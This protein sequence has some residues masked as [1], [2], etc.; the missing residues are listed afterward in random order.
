[1]SNSS[2]HWDP[3][4]YSTHSDIQFAITM[5]VLASYSFNGNEVVLD[6]GCGDGRVSHQLSLRVPEG[7][8]VGID[9]SASMIHFA[10]ANHASQANLSFALKDAC[11]LD[12][13][14]EFDV[15]V[16]TFCL[17]WVPD[18]AAAFGGIRRSLRPGGAAILVM[19]FRNQEIAKLRKEMTRETRWNRHFVDYSDPSDCADDRQYEAYARQAGFKIHSYRIGETSGTFTSGTSFANFLGALTPHLERLPGEED[20]RA[21]MEELVTRYLALMPPTQN[22]TGHTTYVYVCASMIATSG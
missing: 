4:K 8:V 18:K 10:Q 16:S 2:T 11:E 17:Q 7:R 9:S 5:A 20:K 22:N 13:M 21:F 3:C 12:Y 6:A 1:M 19:P 14:Q 15:A